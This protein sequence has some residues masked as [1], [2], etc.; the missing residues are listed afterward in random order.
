MNHLTI[1]DIQV[2]F[3]V[4]SYNLVFGNSVSTKVPRLAKWIS[5]C[6]EANEI[7][8][9]N[10]MSYMQTAASLRTKFEEV[11][12]AWEEEHKDNVSHHKTVR[13]LYFNENSHSS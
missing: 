11:K 12:L 6:T 10:Y 8:S 9:K 7:L 4:I 3:E 1:A 2:F 13:T 5:D